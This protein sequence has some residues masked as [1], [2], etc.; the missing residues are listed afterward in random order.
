MNTTSVQV[1]SPNVPR[2]SDYVFM[3]MGVGV[4]ARYQPWVVFLKLHPF[5]RNDLSGYLANK[6]QQVSVSSST[7]M[8][9]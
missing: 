8:K 6:P 5:L 3:H 7:V 2:V 9:L 1:F 4:E